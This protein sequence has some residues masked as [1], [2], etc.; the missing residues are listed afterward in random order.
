MRSYAKVSVLFHRLYRLLLVIASSRLAVAVV[1]VVAAV[2]LGV[3]IV[4]S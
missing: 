1:L 4:R 2:V 3:A